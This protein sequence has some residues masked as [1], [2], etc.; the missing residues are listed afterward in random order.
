MGGSHGFQGNGGG[1]VVRGTTELTANELP[2]KGDRTNFKELYARSGKFDRDK[3]PPN[4]PYSPPPPRRGIND[5][6]LM[7]IN[8]S[9]ATFIDISSINLNSLS[10]IR[11]ARI[12]KKEL[13]LSYKTS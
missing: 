5:C 12:V 9:Y 2:T 4:P 13:F 3:N 1:S 10:L 8:V 6:S 11:V 7:Q